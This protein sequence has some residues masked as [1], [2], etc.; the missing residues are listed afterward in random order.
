MSSFPW[1]RVYIPIA[2]SPTSTHLTNCHRTA[3]PHGAARLWLCPPRRHVHERV[4]SNGSSHSAATS[5][6]L[7]PI[8]SLHTVVPSM[9]RFFV[10]LVAS[11]DSQQQPSPV[12]HL[13]HARLRYPDTWTIA[14]TDCPQSS[15]IP[16][17]PLSAL[18]TRQRR[19]SG[20]TAHPL[21]SRST[22][23]KFMAKPGRHGYTRSHSGSAHMFSYSSFHEH[24]SMLN[25]LVSGL[26]SRPVANQTNSR[27]VHSYYDSPKQRHPRGIMEFEMSISDAT[28]HGSP[29]GDPWPLSS[30]EKATGR[31]PPTRGLPPVQAV[32]STLTSRSVRLASSRDEQ[33]YLVM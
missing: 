17:A 29:D 10:G 28:S 21:R 13:N 14:D 9:L 33:P 11:V 7:G 20:P 26:E 8:S 6:P 16:I 30:C 19:T 24:C 23:A 3:S 1:Q 22:A 31:G 12:L 18:P 2:L 5:S 4:R 32:L 25:T 27:F 15:I